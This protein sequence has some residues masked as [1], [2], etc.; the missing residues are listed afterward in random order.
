MEAVSART[1]GGPNF[2]VIPSG[3]EWNTAGGNQE[4]WKQL[5]YTGHPRQILRHR[6]LNTA[7]KDGRKRHQD[8]Q[9]ATDANYDGRCL[10]PNTRDIPE[11]RVPSALPDKGHD[12]FFRGRVRQRCQIVTATEY[13]QMSVTVTTV[14]AILDHAF[15]PERHEEADADRWSREQR[16]QRPE[17]SDAA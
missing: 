7:A 2:N 3:S 13:S 1:T 4:T 11:S 5:D 10:P 12:G 6:I 9:S 14:A 16:Q 17:P 15:E 8:A